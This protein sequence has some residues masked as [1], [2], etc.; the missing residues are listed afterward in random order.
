MKYPPL[1]AKEAKDKHSADFFADQ[2]SRLQPL[3]SRHKLLRHL[4]SD[5]DAL[6]EAK[7]AL[8]LHLETIEGSGY[9]CCEYSKV[10]NTIL[11]GSP[12]AAA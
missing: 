8:R 12:V 10:I 9:A 4:A 6:K 5:S 3:F 7:T 11:S 1:F 2:I